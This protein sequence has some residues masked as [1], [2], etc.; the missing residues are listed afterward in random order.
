MKAKTYT[1]HIQTK[2]LP[3][4]IKSSSP[5]KTS[6]PPPTISI[7]LPYS[8]LSSAQAS[9]STP[10]HAARSHRETPSHHHS[11]QH[12]QASVCLRHR[13]V[14]WECHSKWWLSGVL[15]MRCE[16]SVRRRV[17]GRALVQRVMARLRSD[18]GVLGDEDGV[19]EGRLLLGRRG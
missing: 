13:Q 18:S 16:A 5:I 10:S 19:E 15:W 4:M 2:K 7:Y 1:S 8:T 17:S 9:P 11:T 12:F 14:F 6:P 3:K